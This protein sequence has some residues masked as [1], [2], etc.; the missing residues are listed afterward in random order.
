MPPVV[1]RAAGNV[2]RALD[3]PGMLAHDLALGHHHEPVGVDPQADRA[4]GERRRHA[5]AVGFEMHEAGW[6]YPLGV[7]DKAVEHPPQRHQARLLLR[8][9]GGDGSRQHAVGQLAP[10][11]DAARLQPGVERG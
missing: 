4:V 6:R 3:D 10:A 11:L 1:D 9:Q 8:V 7:F 5:V 2:V